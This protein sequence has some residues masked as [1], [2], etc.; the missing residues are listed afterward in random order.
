MS[1]YSDSGSDSGYDSDSN[2]PYI[3]CKGAYTE[4]CE[5]CGIQLCVMSDHGQFADCIDGGFV[6]HSCNSD[7]CDKRLNLKLEKLKTEFPNC[8]FEFA[9][10]KC[11]ITAKYLGYTETFGYHNPYCG[12]YMEDI[13]DIIIR[14]ATGISA[15]NNS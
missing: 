14:V 12:W 15:Q 11:V 6:C 13:D 2:N 8:Q 10:N 3:C 7:R 1:N 5:D 9:Q 4:P